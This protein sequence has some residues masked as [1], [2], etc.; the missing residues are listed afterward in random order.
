[1][2]HACDKRPC[3][4]KVTRNNEERVAV[5]GDEKRT[6]PQRYSCSCQAKM[7]IAEVVSQAFGAYILGMDDGLSVLGALDMRIVYLDEAPAEQEVSDTSAAA[8][9]LCKIARK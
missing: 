4:I 1:M 5:W 8:D 3:I 9:L 2:K 7:T 6:K